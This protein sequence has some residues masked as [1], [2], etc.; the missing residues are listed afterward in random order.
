MRPEQFDGIVREVPARHEVVLAEVG[1]SGSSGRYCV[2]LH[3]PDGTT[4]RIVNSLSL[5]QAEAT[6]GLINSTI[7]AW[8]A[9]EPAEVMVA[10]AVAAHDAMTG[11]DPE[12][13]HS[14]SDEILASFAPPEVVAARQRLYDRC[15]WWACA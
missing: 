12:S 14:M 5:G 8:L 9:T 15:A 2:E 13:D 7:G 4:K 10:D 1:L 3:Q 11:A 6:C